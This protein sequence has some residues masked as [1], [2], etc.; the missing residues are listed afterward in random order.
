MLVGAGVGPFPKSRLDEALGFAIGL[1]RVGFGE[2]VF[3]TQAGAGLA[4]GRGAVAAAVV[5]H[6]PLDG[7]T[8]LAIVGDDLFEEVHRGVLAFV[9]PQGR[10][11]E[12]RVI[13]DADM[14]AFPAGAA[15]V[16][17]PVAGDAVTRLLDAAEFLGVEVQ[18]FAGMFAF[19]AH[20]GR[21]RWSGPMPAQYP[22]QCRFGQAGALADLGIG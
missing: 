11:T 10:V 20:D 15:H 14:E 22:A 17:A 2:E 18:Q 21:R 13:I 6:D 16:V 19:V 8:D 1:G 7:D 12:A 5:G 4:E 9:G 3:Y